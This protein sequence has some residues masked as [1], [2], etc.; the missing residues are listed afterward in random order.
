MASIRLL[1]AIVN[2]QVD[3]MARAGSNVSALGQ[4]LSI[5]SC[6]KSSACDGAMPERSR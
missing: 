3:A 1:R 6:T 5:T 2:I 4:T